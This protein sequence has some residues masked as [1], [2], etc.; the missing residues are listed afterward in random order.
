MNSSSLEKYVALRSELVKEKATLEARLAKINQVLGSEK[1]APVAAVA[2]AK[3]V[4]R[5]LISK[6]KKARKKAAGPKNTLTMKEAV[7]QV[8]KG[9]L[10]TRQE[11][12]D[13]VK[14]IG[15]KFSTKNPFNSMGVLLYNKKVMKNVNG[16]F[17]PVK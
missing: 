15:Y 5:A 13:A 2:P 6:S 4:V 11:I 16:K 9:K 12:L 3:P 14:K 7:L 8:T 10:L 1:A 17:T